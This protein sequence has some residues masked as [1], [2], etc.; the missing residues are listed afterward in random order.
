MLAAVARLSGDSAAR[1]SGPSRGST[2]AAS[3]GEARR[4]VVVDGRVDLEGQDFGAVDTVVQ[5]GEMG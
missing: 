2:R 1:C 5:S 3:V 4:G